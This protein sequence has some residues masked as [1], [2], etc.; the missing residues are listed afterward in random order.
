MRV[1][2]R[3]SE[4]WVIPWV[5]TA[6]AALPIPTIPPM[7]WIATTS[8]E[9]P[10]PG[11]ASGQ[12]DRYFALCGCADRRG[13]AARKRPTPEDAMTAHRVLLDGLTRD[14][15]ISELMSELAPLHPR[16]DTFR[17]RCSCTSPR[18]R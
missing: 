11:S 10:A 1:V 14:A 5:S 2:I 8:T 18:T 9:L 12:P 6:K 3:A 15:D 16:D 17:A 4:P 13:M 7:A